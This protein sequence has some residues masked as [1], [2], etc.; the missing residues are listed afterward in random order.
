MFART[1]SAAGWGRIDDSSVVKVY[2]YDVSILKDS[3]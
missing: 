1:G 3:F 2:S